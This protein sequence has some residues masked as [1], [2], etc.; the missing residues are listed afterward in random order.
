MRAL[1]EAEVRAA[2][3]RLIWKWCYGSFNCS[4]RGRGCC[5]VITSAFALTQGHL[6]AG[7]LCDLLHVAAKIAHA[8]ALGSLMEIH[9]SR[10]CPCHS[11]CLV[12]LSLPSS[13]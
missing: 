13:S 10:G 2:S 3:A 4:G 7:D 1:R 9:R 11:T 6:R 12:L 5:K 8:L